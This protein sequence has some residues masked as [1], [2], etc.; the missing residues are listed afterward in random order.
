MISA[1]LTAK[2]VSMQS[3]CKYPVFVREKG[4]AVH[5]NIGIPKYILLII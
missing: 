2:A 4:D 5:Y 1:S 3:G